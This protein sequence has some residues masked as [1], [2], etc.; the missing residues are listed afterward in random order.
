M[1]M[2]VFIDVV[3]ASFNV[4]GS[5]ELLFWTVFGGGYAVLYWNHRDQGVDQ[6]F[7]LDVLKNNLIFIF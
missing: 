6:S 7:W 1:Y 5:K 3:R 4:H 2:F